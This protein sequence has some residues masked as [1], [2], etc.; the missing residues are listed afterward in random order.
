MG[1]GLGSAFRVRVQVWGLGLRAFPRAVAEGHSKDCAPCT[2]GGWGGVSKT[3]VSNGEIASFAFSLP[4]RGRGPASTQAL[5]LLGFRLRP[6]NSLAPPQK[7]GS[8]WPSGAR[9]RVRCARRLPRFGAAGRAARRGRRKTRRAGRQPCR[10][11][12]FIENP[13]VACATPHE[14]LGG[15]AA[16]CGISHGGNDT[17]R[18]VHPEL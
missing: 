8:E 12:R 10:R 11:R 7:N 9:G 18:V 15:C 1:S 5:G 3:R 14:P 4:P 16:L 13:I 2:K 17:R 6:L